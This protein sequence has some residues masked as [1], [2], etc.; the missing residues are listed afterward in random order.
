MAAIQGFLNNTTSYTAFTAT[1]ASGTFTT[2]TINIY[3][4]ALS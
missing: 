1:M 3:G 2:G 4:L